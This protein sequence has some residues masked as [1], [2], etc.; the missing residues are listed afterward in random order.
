M[1]Y[2]KQPSGSPRLN[3]TDAG[4]AAKSGGPFPARTTS[5]DKRRRWTTKR[6][7]RVDMGGIVWVRDR[8]TDAGRSSISLRNG[9]HDACRC[10]TGARLNLHQV[11]I[12]C[13]REERT[14]CG[15]ALMNQA[16]AFL[17]ASSDCLL[18]ANT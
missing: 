7:Y 8:R 16:I 6:G 5:A 14:R 3:G 10:A 2:C 9:T 1:F 18:I 17:L 12:D 4:N 11:S 15:D 13:P